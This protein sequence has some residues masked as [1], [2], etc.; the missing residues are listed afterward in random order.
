ML[1]RKGPTLIDV[2]I[3]GEQIPPMSV[4]IRALANA[5]NDAS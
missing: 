3:D 5:I 2:R 4:R 1:T